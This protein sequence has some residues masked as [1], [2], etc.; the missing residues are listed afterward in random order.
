MTEI[1]CPESGRCVLKIPAV[2]PSTLPGSAAKRLFN[3]LRVTPTA[4]AK[5]FEAKDGAKA[6]KIECT[7]AKRCTV[8]ITKG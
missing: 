1:V 4:G 8:S 7:T 5:A 2:S 6:I 3:A